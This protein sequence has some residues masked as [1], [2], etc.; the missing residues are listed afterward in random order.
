MRRA[1]HHE[2]RPDGKS[3]VQ[4]S[5]VDAGRQGVERNRD[6]QRG[7]EHRRPVVA[8]GDHGKGQRN[9]AEEERV[10]DQ[11]PGDAHRAHAE[12]SDR[13]V[14]HVALGW[15]QA[16]R[17]DVV[18]ERVHP[19]VE[20]VLRGSGERLAGREESGP[21]AM[22][23]VGRRI[24]R[25]PERPA[26][27]GE[28]PETRHQRQ[29]RPEQIAAGLDGRV[30]RP[31]KDVPADGDDRDDRDDEREL[32]LDQRGHDGHHARPFRAAAQQQVEAQDHEERADG[33]VLAP[34]RR[35]EDHRRVKEEH[36]CGKEAGAMIADLPPDS[37]DCCGGRH[38]GEDERH[39][40]QARAIDEAEDV[41]HRRQDPEHE[42]I[43]RRVVVEVVRAG[44]VEGAGA[45]CGQPV[46]PLSEQD[47]VRE[48]AAVRHE[49]DREQRPHQEAGKQQE[50]ELDGRPGAGIGIDPAPNG[51]RQGQARA[52]REAHVAHGR[53]GTLRV[54]RASR[55]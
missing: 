16:A 40:Q 3:R 55:S 44:L 33:V 47:E 34:D 45:G 46:R 29:L 21:E 23:R 39:L 52:R 41:A 10:P 49:H 32:E 19:D 13:V 8:T 14:D 54:M 36:R 11:L 25:Q 30:G 24:D 48:V 9:Q 51:G 26:Q 2:R 6:Y 38:V 12:E 22:G 42:G 43:D 31:S 15:T 37:V 35:V 20:R 5:L 17:V 7:Q 28:S 27:G 1:R 53:V 4:V 18:R 50:T